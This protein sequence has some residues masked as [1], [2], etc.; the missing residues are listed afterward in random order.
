MAVTGLAWFLFLVAHLAG[1]LFLFQGSEAFNAYAHKIESFGPL[2]IVAEIGLI[3]L[4][5]THIYS[6]IKVSIENRAAR[7]RDY[8]VK[9]T[10]KR[11]RPLAYSR[12][13][14]IGG[15]L[16]IIF[17][18]FHILTFKFGDRSIEDGLYGVVMR[19]FQS[20]ITV[21]WYVLAMVALGMH[22]SHGLGSAFQTLGVGKPSWGDKLRNAGTTFGWIIA[23]GFISLPVWAYFAQ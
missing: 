5:V 11:N 13:M 3:V 4:L 16:L 15:V 20:R 1:N 8:E 17:I 6:G 14:L 9:V 7:P 19:S 23:G 2:L 21:A 22:L 12:S 10:R 18:I